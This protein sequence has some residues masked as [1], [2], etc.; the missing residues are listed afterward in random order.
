MFEQTQN[1]FSLA[2]ENID[3]W[4]QKLA[5]NLPVVELPSD[6]SRQLASNSNYRSYCFEFK[7]EIIELLEQ[8]AFEKNTAIDVILLAV[9]Q[10]F[11]YRYTKQEDLVLGSHSL[12]RDSIEPAIVRVN[13]ADDF[14]FD[15]FLQEVKQTVLEAQA[16]QY[17]SFESLISELLPLGLAHFK[18]WFEVRD[19]N[20]PES[21]SDRELFDLILIV[22]QETALSFEFKY[23]ASLFD[24]TTIERMAMHWQTL[25]HH[26]LTTPEQEISNLPLLTAREREKLLVDWN[27]TQVEYPTD[28]NI[29]QLF[30]LRVLENPDAIAVVFEGKQLTYQEL[31]QKANQLARYLQTLGVKPEVLVGICI[32]RSLE[33]VIGLLGI[34]KAGGAY[35]PFDPHYPEDRLSY[36]LDD[37]KVEV[38]LSQK[39]LVSSLPD[40]QAQVF[41]FDTDW[42]RV[43]QYS[44]D[45][46]ETDIG[47]K[48]LAYVIYTSGSTGK[49]K[50]VM[51]THQGI[52]NRLCWMQEAYQLNS[53]DRVLQKTPFSFDVS[54]WEFFW[55]LMTG[56]TMVVARPEGHKDS[57]YLAGLI[58]RQQIT[59]VHFVPSMLQV[60]LQEP[61]LTQCSSLKRVFCSGEALPFELTKRFFDRLECELHNLYGPTEAAIDVTFWQC[62]PEDDLQV[63]PIGRPIANT[64]TYILDKHLQPVP[65]GVLGELY[66]GGTNLARGY[67]NRPELTEEK[68]IHNPITG[69]VSAR[70]YKTGDLARYRPDGNI[71]FLGRIDHQVKLRG[72]RIELGEIEAVLDTHP[73]IQQAVVLATEGLTGNKRLVAYLASHESLE[74]AQLREFLGV[75]LPEYMIPS[76]FMTLDAI[77]LTPNGKVDRRAL[78]APD[79]RQEIEK[80]YQAPTIE[81]KPIADIWKAVLNLEK[82]G[83]SDN[84]F[85][86]GGNSL[87]AMQIVSRMRQVLAVDLSLDSLFDSPTIA[88]LTLVIERQRQ[89]NSENT[90]SIAPIERNQTLPLSSEEKS[91]WF[92]EKLHPQSCVYNIPLTF[93][94]SGG[95]EI[96]ILKQ[97]LNRIIDR[98]EIFR[99]SFIQVEGELQRAIAT[100]L[101]IELPVVDVATEAEAER[102]AKQE[103]SQPF[104]LDS[105]PLIRAKLLRFTEG[106]CLDDGANAPSSASQTEKAKPSVSLAPYKGAGSHRYW[107]L[108]TCHHIVFDGWSIQILFDELAKYYDALNNNLAAPLPELAIQYVDYAHWQQ[109]WLQGDRYTQQLDYWRSQ[110]ADATPLIELPTDRA[111]PSVQT[112]SGD[113]FN[114]QLDADLTKAL[115]SLSRQEGVTLYMTLLAAFKALLYRYTGQSDLV[116]GSPFANRNSAD[117]EKL[118]GFLVNTLVLRTHVAG[119][120]SVRELLSRVREVT[121]G[122]YA[123]ANL[124]FAKLVKELQP[125]RDLSYNPLFQV[126]FALQKQ[127]PTTQSASSITWEIGKPGDRCLDERSLAPDGVLKDTASHNAGSH[128]NCSM[129]DLTLDLVETATGIEGHFEYN[130]DLFDRETIARMANNWQ[131]L[132]MGM[133]ANPEQSI[134]RLPLLSATE[135][136]TLIDWNQAKDYSRYRNIQQLFE[137]QVKRTPNAVAVVF[138]N[139]QLTYSQLNQQANQLAHYLQSLG[140]TAETLVGICIEKSLEAIVGLWGILK[141]GGA[142]VPLDPAY[143]EE[144][145]AYIVEDANI[146]VLLT[147]TKWK[148]KLPQNRAKVINLDIARSKIATY[149]T[150]N[151]GVSTTDENLAYIIY[152][153]GSTGKPKGVMITHQGFSSFTQTTIQAYEIVPS[154][155][156]LQF[157]SISFDV[158]VEEIFPSLCAGAT[159][160]LRSAEMVADVQTFFQT[161]ENLKLSVLNLP[162]AYWHQLT[163]ELIAKNVSLPESLRLVIIGSEAVL[164]EP[165]KSWQEY[166]NRSG[167][168]QSL[169]L[170]N[171]YGPTETT[172][173][174]T[175]YRIPADTSTISG[176]V[177][178][179]RPL[180]HLQTY[181]L[182]RDRQPVPIGVTG[183]LYIGGA[184]L[185]RGYLNRPDLTAEKFITDPFSDSP[186]AR[187]Y[188]TGDLAKYLPNGDIEYIGRVD[189]QVKIRGFRIELGEIESLLAQHPAISEVAVIVREDSKEKSLV[190]Y[191]V[192]Q[193][194]QLQ[195]SSVRSFLRDRVPNYMIPSGFVFLDAMPLTPNGKLDRRAL[196]E[197]D[198]S[199]PDLEIAP[200]TNDLEAQLVKI[201][202]EVMDIRPLGIHDNFFELGGHS[203]LAV[204]L[205]GEIERQL[206]RKLPLT[207][208][209]EAP[210]VRELA[211]ILQP[212]QSREFSSIVQLKAGTGTPLFLV[213][214]ADGETIL[215]SN[216]A[217]H[218]KPEQTVYG[219]RPRITSSGAPMLPTRM[220]EIVTD[221][222]REIRQVQPQ[223][224]Y[225]IGG[226]CA[227]GV[228]AFEIACQLQAE[229]EEVPL[230]AIIDAISPHGI[231]DN[232]ISVDLDR[233]KSFLNALSLDRNNSIASI[234]NSVKTAFTK[235]SNLVR[236][237]VATRTK[238]FTEHL[239]IKLLRYC[240]D[241]NLTIPPICQNIPLRSI[242]TYAED[243]YL[244]D[245]A[246]SRYRGKLTLWR[247]TEKLGQ[248]NP[249]IDD[250]PA[251]WGVKDPLLGW[252]EQAT[253]GVEAHDIP[254]GHSSMLQNPNVQTMAQK[255]QLYLDS[256]L[257]S[258]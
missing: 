234:A 30:E 26:A 50:G 79:I 209:V 37:S 170:I 143:P 1:F 98:H 146:S 184:S 18:V 2:A 229:G 19:N 8:F 41:C 33:M 190:A 77:P 66:L 59:I 81:E 160:V 11:L 177:P 148:Q 169:Q 114:F 241:R 69:G 230:V 174:A 10:V 243:E 86:L 226:L 61:D 28:K 101:A 228:L 236:Y 154:D 39:S 216:L 123:N 47:A 112:Y 4:Q 206:D 156:L 12:Y 46:L 207:V 135:K 96:D 104:D 151:P 227:G 165:V 49:P 38:L 71:E 110:L 249:A 258:C 3:Y 192:S 172:V 15:R 133:V 248:D 128:R 103:A 118:I 176:E 56:A 132:L 40:H 88:G 65:I 194:E 27:Q 219:I 218:L 144:R 183:E 163:A 63:V 122:A 247:A 196:P 44:Q 237:E 129:F 7:A 29:Y 164:L 134:D 117:T 215:Y 87:L 125:E 256:V 80:S 60:F 231:S 113:R 223:G 72:F 173:S 89:T 162:T 35:V 188:Q 58:A 197:P 181:I 142:Y 178:I 67:L 139:E 83:V 153:S 75:K 85:E 200:P 102:L 119:E 36:M 24:A 57:N 168:S 208:L 21:I 202:S 97:S 199:R 250:T 246:A 100:E 187:L 22:R 138:Q 175:M 195:S 205:I 186:D 20:C 189:R 48:N 253:E 111:R 211:I 238:R 155:R 31:N 157:A 225:L 167:R 180:A 239:K 5:G 141:A 131:T 137:A 55:T 147:K 120:S 244:Q 14:S 43:E 201:W 222:V 235:V 115:N 217:N 204:K 70:L 220:S 251:T 198:L 25:A 214:D 150:K 149:S 158:A 84:F 109:Q 64:Q 91:L 53:S 210:T 254:G 45:N 108:I 257:R 121:S 68:F 245:G 213:H 224:P 13:I 54:V 233:K 17:Y 127:L 140:V 130:T 105:E 93:K 16:H 23:D 166:V 90:S 116:V 159:I 62:Q 136:Q 179:G 92:F 82:V 185:A 171:S 232:Y 51:N 99:T 221:Y 107:L 74:V 152:T 106:H 203:L 32:E 94:L 124:P 9:F 52:H 34:L 145:L 76:I 182:D 252:K 161:C 255:L 78:P 193:S 95:V 240:S 6:R 191:I 242:Y 73:Q 42:H 212:S 126:M